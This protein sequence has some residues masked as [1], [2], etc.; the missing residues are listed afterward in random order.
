MSGLLCVCLALAG[1]D[2]RF[3]RPAILDSTRLER[4]MQRNM[5][6]VSLRRAAVI[7]QLSGAYSRYPYTYKLPPL[8]QKTD[9]GVSVLR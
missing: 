6:L 2:G 7:A 4:S 3:P 1:E 8:Y 9:A 5:A